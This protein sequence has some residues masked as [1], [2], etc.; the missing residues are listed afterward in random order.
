MAP[1]ATVYL[2]TNAVNGKRYVGVTRFSVAHRWSQ[3]VYRARTGKQ[4]RRLTAFTTFYTDAILK[5]LVFTS[6]TA[7]ELCHKQRTGCLHFV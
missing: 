3:H 7:K 5:H 1:A 6:N 2:A 4:E